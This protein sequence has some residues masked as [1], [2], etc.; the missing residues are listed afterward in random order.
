MNRGICD[1]GPY[2]YQSKTL[3]QIMAVATEDEALVV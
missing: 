3:P 2:M 1:A